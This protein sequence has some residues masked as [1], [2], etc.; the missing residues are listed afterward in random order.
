MKKLLSIIDMLLVAVAAIS[1]S[2]G[3]A[4]QDKCGQAGYLTLDSC[5]LDLGA[6]SPDTIAEGIMHFRNTGNEPLNI[7]SI[8]SDC[9]C[10]STS[11]T[12]ESVPPG[13][14]GE[15]K[16]RFNPK[17]RRPGSFRKVLRIRSNAENTRVILSVKGSVEGAVKVDR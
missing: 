16:V 5:T 6:V 3:V 8:F 17:G 7:L 1:I 13:E 2:P 12:A 9:G 15:I 10:T 14:E 4:A 11:Y